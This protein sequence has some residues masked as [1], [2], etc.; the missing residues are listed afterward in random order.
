[1]EKYLYTLA[2][3]L[4]LAQLPGP[5][6]LAAADLNGKV[7][8]VSSNVASVQIEGALMPKAGDPA[9]IFF[10]LGGTEE[11]SVASGR[12]QSVS[13]SSVELKIENATGEVVKG[14]LVHINSPNP[15]RGPPRPQLLGRRSLLHVGESFCWRTMATVRKTCFRCRATQTSMASGELLLMPA[16]PVTA[17]IIWR[18]M[19][20]SCAVPCV[21]KTTRRSAIQ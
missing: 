7:V 5:Y 14:Q 16:P 20:F 10:A 2:L 17:G 11:V 15:Q 6:V 13:D 21:A 4:L 19:T 9:K 3:G 12:V 18:R 1:M 8:E